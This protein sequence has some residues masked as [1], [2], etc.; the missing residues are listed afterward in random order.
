MYPNVYRLINVQEAANKVIQKLNHTTNQVDGVYPMPTFK[1]EVAQ[2]M[3]MIKG[4]TD[5]D[6]KILLRYLG[7]D[8]SIVLYDESVSQTPG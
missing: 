5:D 3:G 4:V 6:V 8:K 1:R 7:K 2:A